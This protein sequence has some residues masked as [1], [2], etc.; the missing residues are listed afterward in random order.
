M[1][2][3]KNACN[4]AKQR[5]EDAESDWHSARPGPAKSKLKDSYQAAAADYQV[6]K[7]I[8][9]QASADLPASVKKHEDATPPYVGGKLGLD[10]N[11]HLVR[12]QEAGEA[13]WVSSASDTGNVLDEAAKRSKAKIDE[14]L[15]HAWDAQVRDIRAWREANQPNAQNPN[16]TDAEDIDR[17]IYKTTESYMLLKQNAEYR[18]QAIDQGVAAFKEKLNENA[19]LSH[20]KLR[21]TTATIKKSCST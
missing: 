3:K 17:Q 19:R 12:N 1:E 13:N 6:K 10:A 7:K 11:N 9:E 14:D 4:D 8:Y 5:S 18:K 16:G 20:T 15:A 21:I 2:A